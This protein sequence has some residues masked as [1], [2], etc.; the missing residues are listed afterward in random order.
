MIEIEWLWNLI[1]VWIKLLKRNICLNCCVEI[2]KEKKYKMKKVR[3]VFIGV[4]FN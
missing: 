1:W 3:N 4:Y 2:D